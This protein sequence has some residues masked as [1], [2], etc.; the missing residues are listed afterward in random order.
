MTECSSRELI[1]LLGSFRLYRTIHVNQW[2]VL[3]WPA[4]LNTI[5]KISKVSQRCVWFLTCSGV[6]LPSGQKEECDVDTLLE[7]QGALVTKDK[8][9]KKNNL[10][11]LLKIIIIEA[12]TNGL[13]WCTSIKICKA[14]EN[15]GISQVIINNIIEICCTLKR[16]VKSLKWWDWNVHTVGHFP[17]QVNV[18]QLVG[19]HCILIGNVQCL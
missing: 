6:L 18:N 3:E 15:T 19:P 17:I 12:L 7:H 10:T 16:A 5:S 8:M 13:S 1:F 11:T 9:W 4:C 2:I 14:R